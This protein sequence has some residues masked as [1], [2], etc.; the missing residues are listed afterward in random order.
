VE[1]SSWPSPEFS[2]WVR[3]QLRRRQWNDAELARRLDMPS[4]TISRWLRG[5][6]QPST[7]SCDLIADVFGVDVD[8]VLTLAGHRPQPGVAQPDDPRT[9]LI[10]MLNRVQLTPDRLAGLEGTLRAWIEIDRA[11]RTREASNGA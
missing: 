4:G 11:A 6:R 7:R 3:Q 8:L 9:E 1:A 5:E 2:G 10:A